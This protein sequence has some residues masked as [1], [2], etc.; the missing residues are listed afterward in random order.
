MAF[1]ASVLTAGRNDTKCLP[2]P[3]HGQPGPELIPK[4]RE[5]LV[6]IRAGAV[7]VLAV[8]DVCLLRVQS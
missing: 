5:L 2:F 7:R 1:I 3:I 6:L 8:D 4:E